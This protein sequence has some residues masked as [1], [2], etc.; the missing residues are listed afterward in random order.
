VYHAAKY[1]FT[2]SQVCNDENAEGGLSLQAIGLHFNMTPTSASFA[3]FDLLMHGKYITPKRVAP[4][5]YKQQV[6]VCVC[7]CS[8]LCCMAGLCFL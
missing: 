4:S 7:V 5:D 8:C 1:I 2:H 6:C 3:M